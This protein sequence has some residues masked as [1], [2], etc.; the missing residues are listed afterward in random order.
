MKPKLSIQL[1]SVQEECQKDFKHVLNEMKRYGYDG[2]EFANYYEQDASVLKEQLNELGLEVSGAHVPFE[3]LRDHFEETVKF[4]KALGNH[5]LIIPFIG[6][7]SLEEWQ[8]KIK[9]LAIIKDRLAKENLV[10]GYHNHAHEIKDIPGVNIL[11][12]MVRLVPDIQ[13]EVDTYWL[14]FAE[15]DVIPWLNQYKNNIKWLHIKDMTVNHDEKESTEIGKGILPISDYLDWAIQNEL[16]WVVV[17][18]EAFQELT[19]I[20]SSKENAKTMKKLMDE[21]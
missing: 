10:L 16:E 11:E 18:Q 13:L 17:E 21:R 8:E 14:A 2:V 12:E 7:E 6:A 9:E 19:P 20:E 1:W 15:I 3:N 4:E 5:S